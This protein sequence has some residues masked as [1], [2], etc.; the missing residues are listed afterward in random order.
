M[1]VVGATNTE[2][3]DFLECSVD[4]LTRRFADILSKSRAELRLRLRRLQLAAA[5]SGDVRMLIFLGKQYLSQSDKTEMEHSAA[6]EKQRTF[7]FGQW[8]EF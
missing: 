2:I 8:L 6:P 3:A 4:T 1:A 7:V 5:L